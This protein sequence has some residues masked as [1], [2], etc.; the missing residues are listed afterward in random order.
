[1]LL[2]D[3]QSEDHLNS[4]VEHTL[5]R[6]IKPC[7]GGYEIVEDETE[8]FEQEKTRLSPTD[9][10][11]PGLYCRLFLAVVVATQEVS[12]GLTCQGSLPQ[13]RHVLLG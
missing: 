2:S 3:L 5:H 12:V 8:L 4:N 10:I 1:M 6:L 13:H 9:T 7:C 11:G